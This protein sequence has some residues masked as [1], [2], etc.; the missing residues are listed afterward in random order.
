ME[1]REKAEIEQGTCSLKKYRFYRAMSIMMT[2]LCLGGVLMG[3]TKKERLSIAYQELQEKNIR[4][5]AAFKSALSEA[6]A[7]ISQLKEQTLQLEASI[8]EDVVT[9][10]DVDGSLY[11][12]EKIPFFVN[13]DDW[14]YVLVNEINP[15]EKDFSVKTVWFS[16]GQYVDARIKED[17]D[18]MFADAKKEGLKL[19]VCSSYREVKKQQQLM[20]SAVKRY[21]RRGMNYTDAF[22]KAREQI[23]LAGTSEHHTGLALDIVGEDH[24]SLDAAQAKTKEAIWLKEHA[25]EYGFILRYPADKE[26]LTGIKFESW[27]FRYVGKEAAAYITEKNLCLEEF[28][29]L[30]QL[31]LGLGTEHRINTNMR[32]N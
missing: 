3:A 12:T 14:R 24:Q 32:G 10:A 22:F 19:M 27:H 6:D 9:L 11:A 7:Q 13:L 18:A 5:A 20:D 21:M 15:L 23:A 31:Q 8:Q 25:A 17:L 29:L 26:E 1:T 2:V 28:V 30:A 16:P 4:E